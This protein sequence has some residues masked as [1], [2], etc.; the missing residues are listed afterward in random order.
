MTRKHY[1]AIAALIR[2]WMDNGT[3]MTG[4]ARDLADELKHDNARFDRGRFLDAC[5]VQQ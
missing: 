5:G 2:S 1:I 4:F 3:D